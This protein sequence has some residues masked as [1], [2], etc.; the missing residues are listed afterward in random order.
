MC[1][2]PTASASEPD[3]RPGQVAR[4]RFRRPERRKLST[5]PVVCVC[6]TVIASEA[7][8]PLVGRADLVGLTSKDKQRIRRMLKKAGDHPEIMSEVDGAADGLRRIAMAV[9]A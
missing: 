5:V 6:D 2:R 8:A 4:R 7:F 1:C 3:V 9:E